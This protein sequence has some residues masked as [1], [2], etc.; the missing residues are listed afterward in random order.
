MLPCW[1]RYA[2]PLPFS[3]GLQELNARRYFM[4]ASYWGERLLHPVPSRFKWITSHHVLLHF[5]EGECSEIIFVCSWTFLLHVSH[6]NSNFPY[7]SPT[8]TQS[9][10]LGPIRLSRGSFLLQY[11]LVYKNRK[12][13]SSTDLSFLHKLAH[14]LHALVKGKYYP[15]FNFMDERTEVWRAFI[16]YLGHSARRE[17]DLDLSCGRQEQCAPGS[18]LLAVM[19]LHPLP[20]Q[21]NPILV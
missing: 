19:L 20:M 13:S 9:H 16:K 15:D 7:T 17:W 18:V 5:I 14:N 21:H 4:S 2:L 6:G 8:H 3:W 10:I 1:L 12:Y 11:H